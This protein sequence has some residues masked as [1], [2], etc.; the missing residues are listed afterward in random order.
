MRAKEQ[1]SF[2]PEEGH[3][4]CYHPVLSHLYLFLG[5]KRRADTWSL[6]KVRK[7]VQQNA[8]LSCSV[9]C[10]G[11]TLPSLSAGQIIFW[12]FAEPCLPTVGTYMVKFQ[13]ERGEKGYQSSMC[14]DWII[15][16]RKKWENGTNFGRQYLWRPQASLFSVHSRQWCIHSLWTNI[17]VPKKAA[18]NWMCSS[19]T[20]NKTELTQRPFLP[21]HFW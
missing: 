15:M 3:V 14:E 4:F 13:E 8:V 5:Q 18:K 21:W 7:S 17:I 10:V 11:V 19:L 20:A 2:R 6:T 12:P 16:N 9:A 1:F